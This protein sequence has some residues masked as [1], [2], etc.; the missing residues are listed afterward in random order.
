MKNKYYPKEEGNLKT[1]V[2]TS[3]NFTKKFVPSNFEKKYPKLNKFFI[4]V[5][6]LFY[7]CFCFILLTGKRFFE[8]KNLNK[9]LDLNAKNNIDSDKE[10]KNKNKDRKGV[11]DIN[12]L[13]EN[14]KNE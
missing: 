4:K 14:L 13:F 9:N 10:D 6:E 5:F 8:K 7:L 2:E 1:A 3:I 12:E 11:K